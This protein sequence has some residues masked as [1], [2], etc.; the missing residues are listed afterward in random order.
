MY[1]MFSTHLN[2]ELKKDVMFCRILAGSF[3]KLIYMTSYW[4]ANR[5]SIQG[6]FNEFLSKYYATMTFKFKARNQEDIIGNL[7]VTK[8][9]C[10]NSSSNFTPAICR[11]V[12]TLHIKY[13]SITLWLIF[14]L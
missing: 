1:F 14:R 11:S 8:I 4:T 10:A 7:G 3:M 13:G 6:V 2:Y 12:K 5:S 9:C